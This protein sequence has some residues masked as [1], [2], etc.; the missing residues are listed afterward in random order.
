MKKYCKAKRDR[1]LFALG[2]LV[3]FM[4][5]IY[6]VFYSMP[7]NDDFALGINWWGGN[8][9]SEGLH[10]VAWNYMHWFGQSGVIAILIQVILNPL[11]W[12][13]NVGHSFGIC[14]VISFIIIVTGIICG[15]RR[16][17]YYVFDIE[18]DIVLDGFTYLITL[19][20][21]T[22]YYYNDVYNWWSGI[23]GYS[24]MMMLNIWC[25]G[26]IAKWVHS[27]NKKD[28]IWMIIL[29]IVTCTSLMNC[30]AVGLFYI[31]F[32]F[33]D[34]NG[35]Y[36]KIKKVIPFVF[37]V[38]SGVITV[39]APG[40]YNRMEFERYFGY[41]VQD[42]KYIFS[43]LVTIKRVFARAILT[44]VYKPWIICIFLGILLLGI[45]C[46]PK[47]KLDI[48]RIVFAIVAVFISAI[49]AVY[50]YVLGSNKDYSSE[51]ANRI[52]FVEDYLVFI[53]LAFVAF[54]IGQ[55]IGCVVKIDFSKR[56][57]VS[58]VI[59][60]F[61]LAII[62][63]KINPYSTA[64][65]PVDIV[66]QASL[67]KETYYFWD[68]ILEEIKNSDSKDVIIRRKDIAWCPYVYTCGMSDNTEKW[69]VGEGIYYS[70]SNQAA[71]VLYG[72]DSIAIYFE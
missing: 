9:I 2:Y 24:F 31:L 29:G 4:P 66:K 41:D 45:Y 36:S 39:A 13:N 28:Y 55:L 46:K 38:I 5:F 42:P 60:C 6:S 53:G 25:C 72:K 17:A 16:L 71:S 23:P 69:P 14:M 49:G 58:I 12:F 8:I 48:K 47:I 65:I 52:Y 70:G 64:F 44:V 57:K 35:G 3:L 40:N 32:V 33:F 50:P 67:I 7:A 1:L 37:F 21:F 26:Q 56:V 62:I 59:V 54:R 22:S 30:V 18:N 61:L 27:K 11:Y 10:R 68:D 34:A 19:L 20:L 43:A 63:T 15:I 51:F